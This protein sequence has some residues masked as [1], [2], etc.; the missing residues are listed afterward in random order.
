MRY[1]KGRLKLCLELL[2]SLCSSCHQYE[3]CSNL[4]KLLSCCSAQHEGKMRSTELLWM[5]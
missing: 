5:A 4:C 2:Q 3:I 1:P